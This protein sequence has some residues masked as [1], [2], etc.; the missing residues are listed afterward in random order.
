MPEE[1]VS[2]VV[3]EFLNPKSMLT[4]GICGAVIMVI[5]NALGAAFALEGPARSF[6]CLGLSFLAGTLVFAAGVKKFWPKL[7]FYVFNSLIIFSAAAGVN[8]SGQKALGDTA[9]TAPDGTNTVVVVTNTVVVVQYVTNGLPVRPVAKP[10][11]MPTTNRYTTVMKA[12]KAPPKFIQS[13][14]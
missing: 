10:V 4:P 8:F 3:G 6:V 1:K 14:K 11:F 13:W 2:A 5:A 9:P 7:A 12:T